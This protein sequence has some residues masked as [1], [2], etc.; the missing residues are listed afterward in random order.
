MKEQVSNEG[1]EISAR[2]P[3]DPVSRVAWETFAALH[4]A[5]VAQEAGVYAGEVEAVHDMRVA[6]RRYR[7]AL[8]N[9]A[10]VMSREDRRRLKVRLEALANA[11]GAVRDLDVLIGLLEQ[12]LPNRPPEELPP[13]QSLIKR[14]RERRRRR[15]RQLIGYL[16]GVEYAAWKEEHPAL[17]P[18]PE[19]FPS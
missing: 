12:S 15:F 11:L 7:V 18:E 5:I 2:S 3:G 6:I 9:F 14:F 4:E 16:R 8:S 17:P 19:Q 10:V 13:T 1:S